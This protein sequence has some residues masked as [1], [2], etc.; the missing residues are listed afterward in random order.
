MNVTSFS[1]NI[2]L[3]YIMDAMHYWPFAQEYSIC[4]AAVVALPFWTAELEPHILSNATYTQLSSKA[5]PHS[6]Y[7]SWQKKYSSVVL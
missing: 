6:N 7:K 3:T 2:H 4:N 1:D 5:T